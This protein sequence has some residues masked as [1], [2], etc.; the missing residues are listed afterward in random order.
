[1]GTVVTGAVVIG[2]VVIGAVGSGFVITPGGV[3]PPPTPPPEAMTHWVCVM[4]P[5]PTASASES[6]MV[7]VVPGGN[8]GDV[9]EPDGAGTV[10][11]GDGGFES[12][13]ATGVGSP[14]HDP[15]VVAS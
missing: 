6:S 5:C 9:T 3:D 4:A 13:P 15:P 12:E 11:A 7:M 14:M 8:T 1:M 2:E 10:V